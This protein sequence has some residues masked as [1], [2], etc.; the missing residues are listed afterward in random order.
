[1]SYTTTLHD[2][3]HHHANPT[4]WR[5]WLFST[6][7]KD[8]GTL[9]LLFALAMLFMGGASAMLIRAE[10]FQ[11]GI[12]LLDPDL[13]NNLVTN[14]ALLMIFG[15]VMPAAAGL[16][17]WMIP[18][19]IGAPDMALPRMNNLSF[20]ILPAAGTMLILSFVVPFFPGGGSQINTG[21][22]LYPPLS[23]QVGMSMDFLIFAIHL[24]GISS[25][26]ASINIIVTLLNMRAPGM[27]MMKMPIF[28]WTWL[29]TAFLLI[30]VVPVLAGGVTMLLF[31]RH[32]GT[33]FFDAAG[34]GDPVLFQHLFW[35]FGHP[36][37]YVLLLPSIGVLSHVIPTF[38]RKPL[39]GYKSMVGAMIAVGTI[40]MV[41]WA[42]HQYT[43]GMSLGAVSYFMI[44][45]IIISIPV[46]L[47]I[48]NFIATMWRGA[49]TFETP[50]L[51]A[52]AIIL[53]FTFGGLSGVMLA[54]VPADMQYHD[55]MFVV[56]HFHYVLM[57]GAVFG[58]FAGVFYWLPKWTGNMYDERLGKIFFW[59]NVTGFNLTF[60]PQHF[61]GLAGMPRR[62]IDYNVMFT[63]FNVISSIGAMIFG[64]SHLLLLYII[65]KT[66][67][68]G[69]K[70]TGQV[71]E[72]AKGLE[73]EVPSPPPFH[74]WETPPQ[75]T[76]EQA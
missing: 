74:T 50:M 16:A 44:G 11:P 34:G 58:L 66:I 61:L 56:A 3:T 51:F 70:A 46:G 47:M 38:A 60:F 57:P 69:E 71:W 67:R 32:F 49:M 19:M 27:T 7:H 20:W 68:G 21:W 29:V 40:G 2:D 1:M 31:D 24:L 64:F 33:S 8:I 65:I 15:A 35:F 37:V 23:V 63:E 53:M 75:I 13:Y 17:N 30:L 14:H 5:R 22:T 76:Q 72:G 52:V 73:W 42:H 10:L 36:E 54:V 43:I 48:F 55:S 41:V 62:I 6:N 4:G 25:I 9:Y 12:Q 59:I 18:L 26:L 28:C 45:T 39:F